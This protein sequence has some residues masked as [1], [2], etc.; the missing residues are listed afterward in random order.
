MKKGTER[1]KV[2]DDLKAVFECEVADYFDL[3]PE[4][5]TSVKFKFLS[6]PTSG[7]HILA[8][9]RT[10]Q[11]N[12]FP[13][14]CDIEN[15]E[16]VRQGTLTMFCFKNGS[17]Y[18][19]TCFHVGYAA[20]EQQYDEILSLNDLGKMRKSKLIED[21]KEYAK[22]KLKYCYRQ[23]EIANQNESAVNL[24]DLGNFCKGSF[25][26]ESDIMSIKVTHDVEI[27]CTV[28]EIDSPSWREI[29]KELQERVCHD[30]K[31]PVRVK[32]V[33]YP[34]KEAQGYIKA[35]NYSYKKEDEIVIK[36]AITVKSASGPFLQP[37]DSGALLSFL[38]SNNKEQAFGYVV[39]EF[40]TDD[41]NE[42]FFICLKLDIALNK[43]QLNRNGC[44]KKCCTN[45]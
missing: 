30:R 28:A 3:R 6:K 27:D 23:R 12:P 41:G 29:W 5:K 36:N 2:L 31:A 20:L 7:D 45:Q 18:A 8:V 1:C 40:T 44:F 13:A 17:H 37:G 35:F 15:K 32:K 22:S 43:L 21:Q 34:S 39:G 24:T 9:N 11:P 42:S 38:D 33:G 19:L 10:H 14:S 25:D 16:F 4:P 26:N